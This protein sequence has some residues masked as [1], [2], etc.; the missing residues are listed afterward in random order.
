MNL[1][2]NEFRQS[3]FDVIEYNTIFVVQKSEAETCERIAEIVIKAKFCPIFSA[4]R[5]NGQHVFTL[6]PYQTPPIFNP[7]D[8]HLPARHATDVFGAIINQAKTWRGNKEISLNEFQFSDRRN[9]WAVFAKSC[10]KIP[11]LLYEFLNGN[12]APGKALELGCGYGAA[13]LYLHKKGWQVVAI[14]SC[15]EALAPLKG[16]SNLVALEKKVEEF[17][18]TE[19]YDLILAS[20]IFEFTDPGEFP[21]L[22]KCVYDAIEDRGY[23]ISS[24]KKDIKD[25]SI[26]AR[27]QELGNWHVRDICDVTSLLSYYNYSVETCRYSLPNHIVEPMKIEFLA[28]KIS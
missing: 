11:S 19:K 15:R 2:K 17:E 1:L 24:F 4:N 16:V 7:P 20:N 12:R 6:C 8:L 3:N 22:W 14:D 10:D 23:L 21:R 28:Q 26:M 13:S 27:S 18:F 9:F 5:I 25:E